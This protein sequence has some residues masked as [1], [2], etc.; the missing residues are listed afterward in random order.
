MSLRSPSNVNSCFPTFLHEY[1][2]CVCVYMFEYATDNPLGSHPKL[3]VLSLALHTPKW[4]VKAH[5]IPKGIPHL[6]SSLP[7]SG[8]LSLVGASTHSRVVMF[9]QQRKYLPGLSGLGVFIVQSTSR[10]PG[11]HID[12]TSL[13]T[14]HLKASS[15]SLHVNL[16]MPISPQ[17]M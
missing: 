3:P 12:L 17:L 9:C 5:T 4:L 6:T 11:L 2:L 10:V 16:G 7:L 8:I 1:M 13:P 15:N 14:H